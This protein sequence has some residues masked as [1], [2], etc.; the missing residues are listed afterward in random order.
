MNSNNFTNNLSRTRQQ[1][2]QL[3]QSGQF[4]Q[5]KDLLNKFQR[6]K[7]LDAESLS[8]LGRINGQLGKFDEAV[9]C[10]SKAINLQPSALQGHIGLGKAHLAVAD[11]NKALEIN[12]DLALAYFHRAL[13]YKDMGMKD[14]AITDFEKFITLTSDPALSETAIYEI[15]QLVKESK[16]KE[17][18]QAP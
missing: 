11:S 16:E 2:I 13:A 7:K 15:S 9:D 14:E 18:E 6:K 12:P 17:N 5:A 4:S 3:C 1:A 10:F 8:L